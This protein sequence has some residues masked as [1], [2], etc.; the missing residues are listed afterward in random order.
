MYVVTG[1]EMAELDTRARDEY[2]LPGLLLMENAGR[3]V[4]AVVEARFG[5]SSRVAV[6]CGPGNN[7]GDGLVAARHL[8]LRGHPVEVWLLT[9]EADYRGDALT[10]LEIVRAIGLAPQK[11]PSEEGSLREA[12]RRADVILDACF[13]TGFCGEP[14]PR[15]AA[16]IRA[17]NEAGRPIVAVDIP[18]GVEAD[19]GAVRGAAVR[20]AITV[21]FALPKLGCLLYPGAAHCGELVV[22]PISLPV[23]FMAEGI[24]RRLTEAAEV[25]ALLPA[26]PKDAHKGLAGRVLVIGGSPGLTGAPFLAARGALRAGAGLVTVL[27]PA[28]LPW[29]EKPAE[30]MLGALPAGPEGGFGPEAA[31]AIAPWLERADAIALGPGL[32][33]GP[34]GRALLLALA[35]RWRGPLVLDADGL[36]LLAAQPDLALGPHGPWVLTPHPGEMARLAALSVSEVQAD[37][38]GL[39]ERKAAEWRAVVVLKGVPTVVADPDG[40][41]WLN[42]TGHPAMATGGMGDVLTGV[43]AGLIAQG[44]APAEAAVAGVYLHGLAGELV[45]SARGGAGILAGEVAEAIPAA[46]EKVK[47]ECRATRS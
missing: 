33:R 44:M 16:V 26:R 25:A 39:A 27:L 31:E 35:A 43:I 40:T 3:E 23:Q 6:V 1:R 10:N 36:N 2:G 12:L 11:V 9:E 8:S 5:P 45:A 24:G 13:G 18:S 46:M 20:A 30:V 38:V 28:D 22:V 21:T 4:A 29:V 47:N 19:T 15:A 14:R 34:G 7:G 32:G 17:M 41:T 37:R 42:P